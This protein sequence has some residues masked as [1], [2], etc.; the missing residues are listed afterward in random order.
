MNVFFGVILF[1]AGA[2]IAVTAALF[3]F[4]MLV[5]NKTSLLQESEEKYRILVENQSV[6][7]VKVDP[8]G[9]LLFVSGSYCEIFGKTEKELIGQKFIPLVH[10]DDRERTL[11]EMEKLKS[12]P[13]SCYIE[14]RA[15]TVNGWRW[16]GWA[17]KAIRDNN[18]NIIAVVGVGRD[19]TDRKTIED[20]INNLK[21]Q[22]EYVL[23][24][25]NTGFDLI[26][27]DYNVIY[28]DPQWQ[29]ILGDFSGK[30][31]YDYFMGINQP[32][33]TCGIPDALRAGKATISEE[34]L[35]KENRYIEV[36]TIPLDKIIDGKRTVA[37]FNIDITSRKLYEIELKNLLGELQKNRKAELNLIEDLKLLN[38]TLEQKVKDRTRDLELSNKELESFSY[39]VSHDL[40]APLRHIIGFSDMMN[41]LIS[42]K[43]TEASEYLKKIKQSATDMG[44]LIDDLLN[45]SKTGREEMRIAR[46]NINDIVSHIQKRFAHENTD[47]KIEWK[48]SHLPEVHCDESLI[49]NVW[50]NVIENAVKYTSKVE[51][52]VIEIGCN[53][54]PDEYEFFIRDNGAGFDMNYAH[55]LFGVFHRLHTKNE[56]EGTGI[57]LANVYKIISRHGG[58][59]YAKGV[60]GEGAEFTFTLPKGK[61]AN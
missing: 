23:G 54:K 32:C 11:R 16:F 41:G 8:E 36:H 15:M 51:N 3:Y 14:Q 5:K 47:R 55:K 39:S 12:P 18:D 35:E 24:A 4:R 29:K 53:E 43:H 44:N 19:I 52:A 40:R 22:F 58:K 59:I 7:V 9:R 61:G 28:V 45:Y 27:E 31:C 33:I 20:E 17:D 25:T 2:I 49:R 48:I 37:E 50:V 21:S 34:F 30:K 10:D 60:T 1:L 6:L 42:E 56:F 13:Y 26:D 38:E 57:G 46:T